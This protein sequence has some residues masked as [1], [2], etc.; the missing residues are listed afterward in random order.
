MTK[1][2]IRVCILGFAVM[3][4]HQTFA[5][6]IT[7]YNLTGAAGSQATQAPASAAA[8]ITGLTMTRGTG[9]AAAAAANTFSSNSWDGTA[10]SPAADT[11]FLSFGFTVGAGFKVDLTNLIISTQASATGPASIGLY[12]SVDSFASPITTF[13]QAPGGN[14]VNSTVNLAALTGLTGS[15]EFRLIQIGNTAANGGTISGA[16]TF[17]IQENGANDVQFNGSVLA[18]PEPSAFAL[19]GFGMLVALRRR[20]RA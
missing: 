7:S 5:A 15:I 19:L 12:Y 1:S 9:V 14:A 13:S 11:E 3:Q 20:R 16:G 2:L 4:T 17:R 6:I 18:V 10:G 8:N